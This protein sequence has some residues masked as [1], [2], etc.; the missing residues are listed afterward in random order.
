MKQNNISHTTTKSPGS[1][2]PMILASG[3]PRRKDLLEQI[4]L[5]FLVIT[6]N[7]EEIST[8]STPEDIVIELSQS[9]ALA[10]YDSLSSLQKRQYPIV[11]GADTIVCKNQQVLGKPK[12]KEEAFAMLSSIA[13]SSH[14]VYTGV[15]LLKDGVPYSFSCCTQVTVLPMTEEEIHSYIATGEPFDKAGGYGIQG[16]FAAYIQEIHGDYN[17]V[18][19]LP[20]S[21]V[22]QK[23]KDLC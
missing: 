3:S 9:K 8:K 20:V 16:P 10:V 14:E 4:G 18:V 19:G 22:Y 12:T 15:T 2:P 21:M 17:N 5:T 7:N 11:L 6:S 1:L 23:L 13:A